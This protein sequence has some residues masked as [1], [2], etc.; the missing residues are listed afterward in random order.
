MAVIADV[1][2]VLLIDN[3][4]EAVGRTTVQD[5]SIEVTVQANDVNGGRGNEL[6]GILHATRDIVLS[7][8]WN[9]SNFTNNSRMFR[10]YHT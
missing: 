1:F 4:G 9:T 5:G 2:E 6:I 7:F 8:D 3:D 10:F